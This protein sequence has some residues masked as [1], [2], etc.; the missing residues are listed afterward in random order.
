ML[1]TGLARARDLACQCE[2]QGEAGACPD[3][4]LVAVFNIN[5]FE[6]FKGLDTSV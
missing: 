5:L 2:A 6:K 3:L 1:C 4:E